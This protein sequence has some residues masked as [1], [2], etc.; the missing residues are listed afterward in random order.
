[1]FQEPLAHA[2]VGTWIWSGA[3]RYLVINN[4]AV[5][6]RPGEYVCTQHGQEAVISWIP[7]DTASSPLLTPMMA[8]P[9]ILLQMINVQGVSLQG[10]RFQHAD[11]KGLDRNMNFQQAAVVVKVSS[12]GCPFYKRLSCYDDSHNR[13][14]QEKYLNQGSRLSILPK[15]YL[16]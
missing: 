8:G 5:L 3:L 11:Y 7:P 10:I 14:S 4:R 6:D 16:L 2:A 13:V 12:G 15:V 1:M 9:E